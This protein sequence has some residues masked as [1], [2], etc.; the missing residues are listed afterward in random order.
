ME[1]PKPDYKTLL[2]E[3]KAEFDEER[4]RLAPCYTHSFVQGQIEHCISTIPEVK[5]TDFNDETLLFGVRKELTRLSVYLQ[6]RDDGTMIWSPVNG[7]KIIESL[8]RRMETTIHW[9]SVFEQF[10]ARAYIRFEN[11]N[12]TDRIFDSE[13]CWLRNVMSGE[14][15][16]GRGKRQ[17]ASLEAFLDRIKEHYIPRDIQWSYEKL[18]MNPQDGL[19][20]VEWS[21]K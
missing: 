16:V 21:D 18:E 6:S 17:F 12:V 3:V 4:L 19:I 10:S 15:L 5:K 8:S 11:G 13:D 9:L 14:D 2:A 20:R 1:R 7:L